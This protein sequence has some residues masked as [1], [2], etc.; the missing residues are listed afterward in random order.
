MRIAFIGPPGAGKSTQAKR[1]ARSLPYHNHSPRFSSGELVRAEIEAGT[2]LGRSLE[3]RFFAPL[4]ELSGEKAIHLARADDADRFALA[5]LEPDWPGSDEPVDRGG[6]RPGCPAPVRAG[7]ARQ[8]AHAGSAW[9]PRAAHAGQPG[10]G[11]RVRRARFI[12]IR[13]SI[14]VAR[15]RSLGVGRERQPLTCPPPPREKRRGEQDRREH[16][17]LG[18]Q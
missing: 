8:R 11:R 6:S 3:L 10:R 12:G 9:G 4:G 14:S 15:P 13:L 5:A 2:Q 7:D 16:S 1:V 18:E 17:V